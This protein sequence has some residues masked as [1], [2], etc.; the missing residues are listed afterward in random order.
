MSW[1]YNQ[2]LTAKLIVK[3]L[4]NIFAIK[5]TEQLVLSVCQTL[6]HFIEFNT[7][8][9]FQDFKINVS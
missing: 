7:V 3:I 2:Q 4:H 1:Y 5:Y 8:D 6:Y 9:A